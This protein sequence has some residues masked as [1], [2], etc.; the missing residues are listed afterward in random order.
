MQN[1]HKRWIRGKYFKSVGMRSWVF[2]GIYP[3]G[4]AAQLLYASDTPIKRHTKIKGEANPYDPSFEQYFEKRLEYVWRNSAQGNK[5]LVDLWYRQLKRC[6]MCKQFITL[7][8]RWDIHHI[9]ERHKGGN[10]KLK[11]LVLLHPNCHRQLHSLT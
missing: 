4:K 2:S 10:S 1:R 8:S 11:N 7:E 3:S 9:F 6:P 5:K